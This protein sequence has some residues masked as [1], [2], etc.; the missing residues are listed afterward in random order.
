MSNVKRLFVQKILTDDEVAKLQ[1]TWI[2]ESHI[3]LPLVKE[4]TDVYYNDNKIW[5]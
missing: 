1:G 4:D 3:K 5:Q 2:D